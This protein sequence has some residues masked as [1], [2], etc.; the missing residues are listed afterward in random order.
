M[1]TNLG[2]DFLRLEIYYENSKTIEPL[3]NLHQ[4]V[5]FSGN[6]R[7][8]WHLKPKIKGFRHLMIPNSFVTESSRHFS[9]CPFWAV[10]SP[11]GCRKKGG[12][13]GR[14]LTE[15]KDEWI[16]TSLLVGKIIILFCGPMVPYI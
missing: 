11:A 2:F 4:F 5:D 8:L 9:G 15:S 1:F 7:V 3:E 12:N 14:R 6:Y 16:P 10:C 13:R